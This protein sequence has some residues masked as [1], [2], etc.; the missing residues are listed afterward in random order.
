MLSNWQQSKRQEPQHL[1]PSRFFTYR[2][3]TDLFEFPET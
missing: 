3:I 1:P 2:C